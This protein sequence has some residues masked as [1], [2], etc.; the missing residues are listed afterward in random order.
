MNEVE[1]LEGLR[2]KAVKSTQ[3]LR[4]RP[5]EYLVRA[6]LAGV[7]IGFAIIFTLKAINGLYLNES[8][9]TTLVGGLTF[10]VALVLIVYGGAEL[11]TGNT[12]YFTT[13]TMRGFTSKMD[14]LKVWTLCFIGNGLG[15][16]AFALLFSQTGIIQELGMEN[17]LFAVSETKIH[18]TTWE[19]FTRAIFCNWM[20]C[21]AIFIPKNMKNE[22]AQIMMMMILVAVFFASGFD[23]VIANMAL[24]SLA[25]VVPHPEAISFAGAI[26]NLVP[27]LLGNIIGGALFMGM[28]YTWLNKS[29]LE[30][31][32]S[33][34]QAATINIASKQKA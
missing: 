5:L 7:F 32:Q 29:K 2:K 21:L 22:L 6:M 18:H 3:M 17:W 28:V 25:L 14:T 31:E 11:F 26:H 24:F 30:V 13:S 15:G 19:I 34:E 33:N 1:A 16:L 23:H 10:G 8:P 4:M 9:V 27:A 20:V 12:M